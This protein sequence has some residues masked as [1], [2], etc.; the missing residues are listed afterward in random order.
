MRERW[1]G[2]V[3]VSRGRVSRPSELRGLL[4]EADGHPL[5]LVTYEV[6]ESQCEVV[7]LDSLSEKKGI[8][9]ALMAAVENKARASG[10]RRLWL[11]TTNDNTRALRFYQKLGFTLAALHRDAIAESRKLKPSIALVGE[12]GIQIRDEVELEKALAKR[13]W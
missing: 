2:E 6:R 13:E 1:G 11:I 3:V 7:T 8:G 9:T 10:C 12:D 5:G 4:A